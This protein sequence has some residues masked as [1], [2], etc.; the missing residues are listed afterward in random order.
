MAETINWIEI[1][2]VIGDTKVTFM[3]G[4]EETQMILALELQ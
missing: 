3:R 1:E 2:S 4:D